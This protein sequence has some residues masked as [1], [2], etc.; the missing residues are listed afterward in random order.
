MGTAAHLLLY[1]GTDNA[2][3]VVAATVAA[4]TETGTAPMHPGRSREEQQLLLQTILM[5]SL[6]EQ[7]QGA[8]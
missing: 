1:V 3:A 5:K 7:E 4:M 2:E 6:A 8:S